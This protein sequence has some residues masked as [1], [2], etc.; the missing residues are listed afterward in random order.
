MGL[1]SLCSSGFMKNSSS[2]HHTDQTA[3]PAAIIRA[4]RLDEPW[5]DQTS[6]DN[7]PEIRKENLWLIHTHTPLPSFNSNSSSLAH[8]FDLESW[9]DVVIL[10]VIA[11][12]FF[13]RGSKS[14]SCLEHLRGKKKTRK[15][16]SVPWMRVV[17]NFCYFFSRHYQKNWYSI[18][19][20]LFCSR[21]SS[22]AAHKSYT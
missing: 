22:N 8:R 18:R 20:L 5:M 4:G 10:F 15:N 16:K 21:R 13:G 2:I 17:I 19:F 11:H 3:Q 14:I 6:T 7:N 1:E 12:D 9:S